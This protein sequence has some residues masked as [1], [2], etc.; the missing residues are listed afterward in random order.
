MLYKEIRLG[1]G[2]G[3]HQVKVGPRALVKNVF[4][5]V[6]T[7]HMIKTALLMVRNVTNAIK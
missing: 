1:I 2:L 3:L 7:T 4:D 5:V 6:G